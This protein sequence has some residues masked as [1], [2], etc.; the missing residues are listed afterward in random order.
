MIINET[1]LAITSEC[2]LKGQVG[3][4]VGIDPTTGYLIIRFGLVNTFILD[5]PP[6]DTRLATRIK[7]HPYF[8][9]IFS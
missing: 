1:N 5:F 6:S 8:G 3:R 4:L 7:D 9:W 2:Y